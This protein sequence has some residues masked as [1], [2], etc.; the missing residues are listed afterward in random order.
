[1]MGLSVIFL[2][3][4]AFVYRS[5]IIRLL[6][7]FRDLGLSLA[8]YFC[9]IFGIKN[10]PVATVAN[11]SALPSPLA[12]SFEI[13]A[14]QFVLFW[15]TFIN[16]EVFLAY[17]G[18]FLAST[19]VFSSLAII[20]ILVIVI[21]FYSFK[22]IL[23]EP[24]QKHG[25]LT[26]PLRLHYRFIEKAYNPVKFWL[27]SCYEFLIAHRKYLAVFLVIWLLNL[28]VFTIVAEAMAFLFYFSV[29]FDIFNL[30]VQ[31]F[32]LL[33]DLTYTYNGLPLMI[34]IPIALLVFDYLRKKVGYQ[35][36]RKMEGADRGFIKSLA[37]VSLICG[38]MGKKKT[39]V[40]TDMALSQNNIFREQALATLYKIEL[41]YPDFPF[42]QLESALKTQIEGGL[43]YNL[44]GCKRYLNWLKRSFV[45]SLD[46]RQIKK[47]IRRHNKKTGEDVKVFFGYD[48][49]KFPF[50][51]DDKLKISNVF[52]D[53]S[54][55]A[56][57]FFIYVGLTYVVS[58]YS[59][60]LDDQLR[61]KGN[62]ALWDGDFFQRDSSKLSSISRYSKILDFDVLRLGQTLV[63][64]N[65]LSGSFEF[66][67]IAITEIGKERLNNLELQETKK[68]DDKANQKND[69][70]NYWLKM[71]R[72]SSTV[73]FN[74][75]IKLF[76]DE[77]RPESWGADARDL[78]MIGT[79]RECDDDERIALPFFIWEDYFT[80]LA[81]TKFKDFYYNY[82]Y[83][84]G[85]N[86][87][88]MHLLKSFI[89]VLFRYR[90]RRFNT[91]GYR[92]V[93]IDIERG[94]QDGD[95]QKR[96]Y[97]LM[98]KKIY[99]DRFSSDCF[100]E[101]FEE[102]ALRSEVGLDLY[103]EYGSVKA[104][105]EELQKQNSYFVNSILNSL[106]KKEEE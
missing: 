38:T 30:G 90:L 78:A 106:K 44:A 71:C 68:K 41:K 83:L 58:N 96:K 81:I 24:N 69:L 13:F 26:K 57:A 7:A 4:A 3:L 29:S 70:L 64:H 54:T 60:R 48:I 19:L 52:E 6:E 94:T 39:T 82:R 35:M 91:F 47:S 16:K 63:E 50:H 86:C 32:K 53:L 77:Q 100:S 72:H 20:F 97:Y 45:M 102:R 51:F 23:L 56:E 27:V 31:G 65:L 8:Y 76:A 62:F 92:I 75:Y 28:N 5:S 1:M 99:S 87:L 11:L 15:I 42:I 12:E 18:S 25:Q 9:T 61:D 46:D 33:N 2:I 17:I 36:L 95:K 22:S 93:D 40:I 84:R 103:P 34:W 74:P 85:D 59:I 98:N 79:I 89:N 66:G 10:V 49:K 14:K 80:E 73:D 21:C 101:F 105:F 104:S 37:I 43:I 88:F 55:Y 67:V